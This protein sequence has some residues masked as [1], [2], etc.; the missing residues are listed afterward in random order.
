MNAIRS[1]P[2]DRLPTAAGDS[3]GPVNDSDYTIPPIYSSNISD[4]P[5]ARASSSPFNMTRAVLYECDGSA[6]VAGGP[7]GLQ[8][9][10]GGLVPS[11]VGS[12]PMH[13]RHFL[14]YHDVQ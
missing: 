14:A 9:R 13:F 5:Q 6:K 3:N 2:A 12:I 4:A 1:F 11:Q 10:S 8:I 7:P